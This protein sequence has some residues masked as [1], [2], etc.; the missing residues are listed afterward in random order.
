MILDKRTRRLDL[1][2]IRPGWTLIP[3]DVLLK[4]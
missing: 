2:K 3:L 4:K 1:L